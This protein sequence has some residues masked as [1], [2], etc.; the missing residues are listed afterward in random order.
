MRIETSVII[1]FYKNLNLLKSAITSALN[2]TY[3]KYEIIII[4]DNPRDKKLLQDL[5]IFIKRYKKKI[6]LIL[7]DKNIGAG[8]SRNKGIK[9]AKGNFIA[10]LDSDD[11]WKKNKLSMQINIMKKKKLDVTHTSYNIVS[12]NNKHIAVRVAKNLNYQNLL[13][14]CD[15]GLSTVIVKKQLIKKLFL[16]PDIKTKEDYVLWLKISKKGYIFYAIKKALTDWRN[17]PNSLS[18]AKIQKIK[19]AF[20][21]Y[22][23]YESLNLL[24]SILK[25]VNLSINFIIKSFFK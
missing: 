13:S 21:V 6:R 8:L 2:Q 22:Y 10:F 25:T 17:T 1:P 12:L 23:H 11:V 3:N 5:K 9:H 18:K 14:S 20:S 7:N 16:F 24:V 19:D 15:I 4:F